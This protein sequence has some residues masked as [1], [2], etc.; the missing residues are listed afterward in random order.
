MGKKKK[1]SSKRRAKATS[2][3]PLEQF[4]SEVTG[5]YFRDS[6]LSRQKWL[7][8]VAAY[9]NQ[10]LPL[11]KWNELGTNDVFGT[12]PQHWS[13]YVINTANDYGK[14]EPVM[15]F[16]EFEA[17]KPRDKRKDDD[18]DD[19][20]FD[21]EDEEE[22]EEEDDVDDE[23]EEDDDEEEEDEDDDDEDEESLED[24][25][26]DDEEEDDEDDEDEDDDEEADED[27]A[28]EDD[29]DDDSGEDDDE[30][31][32]E[33]EDDEED[34]VIPKPTRKGHKGK[35]KKKGSK[36]VA[37]KKVK[38]DKKE[39]KEKK[40]KDK[41]DKKEKKTKSKSKDNGKQR[42]ST[43]KVDEFGLTVGSKSSQAALMFKK[44]A[45]M[46]EVKETTGKTHY[47]LLKKLTGRGCKVKKEG[48]K[49]F[50]VSGK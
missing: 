33:E 17:S 7:K 27:D 30:D 29:E 31:E 47:N 16:N 14:E 25:D 44:G 41:G 42:T 23:D 48:A 36:K 22:E 32:E 12:L 19:D 4:I 37:D 34:E 18:D 5:K 49:Y 20:E 3:D 35:S 21:E 13:N 39:K 38:K 24:D 45:K 28:E 26:D 50:L 40:S 2:I 46:S 9:I 43:R 11:E 10:V 1:K 15:D 6:D 8:V